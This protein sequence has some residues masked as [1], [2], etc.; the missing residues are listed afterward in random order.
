[1]CAMNGVPAA[2][3]VSSHQRPKDDLVRSLLSGERFHGF[4]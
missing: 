3:L 4:A 2:V 1:M